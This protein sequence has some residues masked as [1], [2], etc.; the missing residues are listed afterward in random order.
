MP[1][2]KTRTTPKESAIEGK[3]CA[4]AKQRG[5]LAYKFT[6]PN[7]RSVPDRMFI[8]PQRGLVFFIEFKAKGKKPTQAQS[9][10][11]RILRSHH[12]VV[13]II[14]NIEDGKR[15][16]DRCADDDASL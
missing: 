14:D 10:E 8:T 3:V 16:I 12:Q 7:R 11:I 2:A 1:K 6:S 13:F 5:F 9:D 15:L 4:Y